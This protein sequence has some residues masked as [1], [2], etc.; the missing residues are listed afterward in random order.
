[1]GEVVVECLAAMR[2]EC[3]SGKRPRM[4]QALTGR[5]FGNRMILP[6]V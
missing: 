3:L 2:D 1:M 6:S 4:G 5:W